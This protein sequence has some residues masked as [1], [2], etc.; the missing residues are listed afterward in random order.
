M[1]FYEVVQ[2]SFGWRDA[3]LPDSLDIF[4]RYLCCLLQEFISFGQFI[5]TF[6][7]RHSEPFDEAV[8]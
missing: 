5:C 2:V 8:F 7:Y 3:A 6:L 1:E 4:A